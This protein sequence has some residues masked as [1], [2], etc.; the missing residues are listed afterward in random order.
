[1]RPTKQRRRNALQSLAETRISEAGLS[2][3]L[4]KLVKQPDL[5]NDIGAS[6]SKTMK[7]ECSAMAADILHNIGT[8]VQLP[9]E[10]G[11]VHILKIATPQA[12]LSHFVDC[13]P[14]FRGANHTRSAP[15][16]MEDGAVS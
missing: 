3:I 13:A 9:M 10:S 7:M 16:A 12:V 1:M 2:R 5:I 11:T 6:S 4:S 14:A 15:T 8:E